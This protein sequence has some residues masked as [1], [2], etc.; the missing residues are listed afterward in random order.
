MS[1]VSSILQGAVN[2]PTLVNI[3]SNNTDHLNL[4]QTSDNTS[5]LLP[6]VVTAGKCT[7]NLCYYQT[8][9][10]ATTKQGQIRM[11]QMYIHV[12][13]CGINCPDKGSAIDQVSA[14]S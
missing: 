11:V 6:P 1:T 2:Q 3:T 9:G 8:R 13:H 14:G 5:S 10:W 4:A 12:L 7:C